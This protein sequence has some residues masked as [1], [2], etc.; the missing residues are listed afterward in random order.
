ML[1]LM[2]GGGGGLGR[3]FPWEWEKRAELRMHPV[4]LF[5][6]GGLETAGYHQTETADHEPEPH[7]LTL[8]RH[9]SENTPPFF[10]SDLLIGVSFPRATIAYTTQRRE[11]ATWAPHIYIADEHNRDANPERLVFHATDTA[12]LE[13]PRGWSDNNITHQKK[14]QTNTL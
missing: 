2:G 9:T 13:N 12:A 3:L 11:K 4:S 8:N 7:T 6:N 10:S 1:R 14:P 5:G